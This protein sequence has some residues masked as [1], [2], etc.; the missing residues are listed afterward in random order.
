MSTITTPSGATP[1]E[2]QASL[3]R[4]ALRGVTRAQVRDAL[5]YDAGANIPVQ[6]M[7]KKIAER[8]GYD[9]DAVPTKDGART[10]A[11]FMADPRKSAAKPVKAKAKKAPA[12]KAA[13]KTR[14]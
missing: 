4:M 7:L 2:R 13:K 8:Y 6:A 10:V 12:K 11:Y 14:H 5:E 3:I 9:F 1:T